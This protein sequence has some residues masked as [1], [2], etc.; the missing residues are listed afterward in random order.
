MR[1][2]QTEIKGTSWKNERRNRRGKGN[3]DRKQEETGE[4]RRG[5]REENCE[6]MD[7]WRTG[8]ERGPDR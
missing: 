4:G 1:N 3:K 5:G 8:G 7:I 6:W 2:K